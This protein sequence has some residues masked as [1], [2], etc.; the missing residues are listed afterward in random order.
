MI[1]LNTKINLNGCDLA[2]KFNGFVPVVYLEIKNGKRI[3]NGVN[4][5][6]NKANESFETPRSS[7]SIP[8]IE[9][10]AANPI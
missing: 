10:T 5:I 9:S 3:S 4:G 8:V 7:N 6:A 1:N 2:N